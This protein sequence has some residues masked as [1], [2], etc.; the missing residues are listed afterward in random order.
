[1]TGPIAASSLNALSDRTTTANQ[2][3]TADG[4]ERMSGRTPR[5]GPPD[6]SSCRGHELIVRRP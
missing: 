6:Q 5:E 3:V 4:R 1:M 2:A